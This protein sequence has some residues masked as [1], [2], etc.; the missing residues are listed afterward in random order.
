MCFPAAPTVGRRRL[1]SEETLGELRGVE[2]HEILDVFAPPRDEYRT[3]G[4]GFG[5]G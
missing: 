4:K 5:D 1:L 2:R 3:A